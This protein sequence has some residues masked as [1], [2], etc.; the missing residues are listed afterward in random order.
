L[1]PNFA[2]ARASE[3][4]VIALSNAD[5]NVWFTIVTTERL[6]EWIITEER[7]T[8]PRG[9]SLLT[10]AVSACL[11]EGGGEEHRMDEHR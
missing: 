2:V 7:I 3:R 10:L 9:L 4:A 8:R 5:H 1:K 6:A 11:Q